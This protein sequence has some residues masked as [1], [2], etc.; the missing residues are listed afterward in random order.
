[1]RSLAEARRK[2]IGSKDVIAVWGRREEEDLATFARQGG[3]M[4]VRVEDGFLRSVGLGADFIRPVSLVFDSRGIYFDPTIPSDLDFIF[5]ETDFTPELLSRAK[6]VRET[7][8]RERL[9]KY[10]VQE[11]VPPRIAPSGRPA[12][13]VPGQVEDDASIRFGTKDIR[14]NLDL[15]R[16]VRRA[17]PEAFIIFKPHPDVLGKNRRGSLSAKLISQH[18]DHVELHAS[19]ARCIEASDEVHTM[20][21]LVGFDALLRGK[22]VFTYGAPFYAGWGLTS[23]M[24]SVPHRKRRL[25]LDELVAGALLLYPRYI[26]QHTHKPVDCE[27]ALS[28]L[29]EERRRRGVEVSRFGLKRW[30]RKCAALV[31]SVARI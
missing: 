27:Q 26:D 7:I 19:A 24:V 20:T 2:G 11:D 6:Q 14:T 31:D 1:M 23:D 18:C 22:P 12:I 29:I 15:L 8:C 9:S 25:H 30:V 17:R 16:A 4:F 13:L 28:R 3:M 5:N 10:N 21:S